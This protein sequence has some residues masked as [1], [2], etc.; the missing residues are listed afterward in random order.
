MGDMRCARVGRAVRR[1]VLGRFVRR[2]AAGAMLVACLT[3]YGGCDGTDSN[4]SVASTKQAGPS[5]GGGYRKGFDDGMASLTDFHAN[6]LWLWTMS[7]DYQNEYNR[8]WEDGRNVRRIRDR[9][10]KINR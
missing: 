1:S 7:E 5:L 2:A 3:V 8:G 9:Q 4:G 10:R 6:W